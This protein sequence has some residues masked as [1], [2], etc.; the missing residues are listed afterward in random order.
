MPGLE[1]RL[2]VSL[3]VCLSVCLYI[4]AIWQRPSPPSQSE[5][6]RAGEAKNLAQEL[7]VV[8]P[9]WASSRG[10]SRRMPPLAERG[11]Q[12][13]YKRA[14]PLV[15]VSPPR[16]QRCQLTVSIKSRRAT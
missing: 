2:P 13:A 1:G 6:N 14:S 8:D 10:S 16:H 7:A 12:E 11:C 5:P 3:S 15:V 9:V 4:F